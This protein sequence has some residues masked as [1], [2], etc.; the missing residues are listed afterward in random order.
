MF[1][2][3]YE[4]AFSRITHMSPT[5]HKKN[6]QKT[7]YRYIYTHTEHHSYNEQAH[8]KHPEQKEKASKPHGKFVQRAQLP[9][10]LQHPAEPHP[11][12]QPQPTELGES[13]HLALQGAKFP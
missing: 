9:G 10:W 4:I 5:T 8:S 3:F 7:L 13:K 1:E 6:P 2:N 11:R 12:R